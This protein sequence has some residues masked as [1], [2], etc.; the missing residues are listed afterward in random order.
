MA[1]GVETNQTPYFDRVKTKDSATK[2]EIN[3]FGRNVELQNPIECPSNS[4]KVQGAVIG[5][6]VGASI[7]GTLGIPGGP[8]GIIA[9][10]ILG[11][12]AG[13]FAGALIA[14]GLCPPQD[15]PKN[16]ENKESQ[17][18]IPREEPRL[19][20]AENASLT[21]PVCPITQQ[22]MVEGVVTPSGHVFE[23]SALKEWLKRVERNPLTNEL[24]TKE[25]LVSHE[26]INLESAKKYVQLLLATRDGIKESQP[27]LIDDYN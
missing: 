10:G 6:F 14:D 8:P 7:G 21:Y 11:G 19:F 5:A 26:T 1:K 13:A 18:S 12:T 15:V 27:G 20:V 23:K 22:P 9:G 24:L 4:S 25:D 2:K 16:K 3:F 17:S